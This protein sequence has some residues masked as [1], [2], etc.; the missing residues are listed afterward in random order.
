LQ[1]NT[2][3]IAQGF[4]RQRTVVRPIERDSSLV[5][6]V[7][8]WQEADQGCLT[9][10]GGSD[11]SED[12]ARPRLEGDVLQ[13]VHTRFVGEVDSLIFD[14]SLHPAGADGIG[15][16]LN[17]RDRVDQTECHV[18]VDQHFLQRAEHAADRL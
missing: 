4:E 9:G 15:G 16:I 2:D 10:S 18:Q 17:V 8:A 6:V 13:R 5:E 3:L 11:N 14:V 1:H 7:E 12:L